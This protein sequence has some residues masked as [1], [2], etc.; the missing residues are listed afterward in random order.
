MAK[1]K[2]FKD[3][4]LSNAFLFAVAMQDEETCRIV[5]ETVLDKEI[6]KVRVN[7]LGYLEYSIDDYVKNIVMYHM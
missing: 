6:G 4:N 2:N 7:L 5:L 3:L 1:T